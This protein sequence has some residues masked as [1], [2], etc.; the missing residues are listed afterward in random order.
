MSVPVL[1]FFN[2]KGESWQDIPCLSSGMDAVKHY[3]SLVPMAQEARKPIFHLTP[4][5]GAIGSHAA[6]AK[7]AHNDFKALAEKITARIKPGEMNPNDLR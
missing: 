2:N 5:D 6:S 7:D 4:A 3:R 1:T